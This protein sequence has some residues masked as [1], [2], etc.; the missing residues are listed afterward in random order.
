MRAAGRPCR[1]LSLTSPLGHREAYAQAL[2]GGRTVG[3]W[4]LILLVDDQVLHC[5]PASRRM[6]GPTDMEVVAEAASD[7][8]GR[9][10]AP[11]IHGVDVILMDAGASWMG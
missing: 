11:R 5:L 9:S 4:S 7:E 8:V 6:L 10:S 1:R 3:I 2:S